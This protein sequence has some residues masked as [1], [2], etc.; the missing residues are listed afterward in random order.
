MVLEATHVGKYGQ[1]ARARRAGIRKG[2]IVISCDG[3]THLL[4][5]TMINEY[6]VQQKKPGDRVVIEYMRNGKRKTATIKLQ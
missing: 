6:A 2:D 4:S 3:K 5:E 1:H